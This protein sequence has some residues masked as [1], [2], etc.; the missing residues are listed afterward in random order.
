M[1]SPRKRPPRVPKPKPLP[2]PPTPQDWDRPSLPATGDDSQDAIYLSVGRALTAWERLEGVLGLIFIR[3]IGQSYFSGMPALRAYGTITSFSGRYE[4]L[5]AAIEAA[6][7]EKKNNPLNPIAENSDELRD[8]E[9]AA[10]IL[11]RIK[12]FS[13]RRNEIAHGIVDKHPGDK[14]IAGLFGQ[15]PEFGWVLQPSEYATTKKELRRGG[16]LIPAI[17]EP[18]Y[19]YTAQQIDR[20]TSKFEQLLSDARTYLKVFTRLLDDASSEEEM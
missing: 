15:K 10:N 6:I 18:R 16:I 14:S 1:G 3:A 20:F 5:T 11:S 2:T 17:Q 8:V 4:M 7:F 12:S 13:A 9:N 19:Y